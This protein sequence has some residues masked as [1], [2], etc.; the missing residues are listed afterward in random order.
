M[1]PLRRALR[2]VAPYRELLHDEQERSRRL[3]AAVTERDAT[4]GAL[5]LDLA[6]SDAR[7]RLA[8][9]QRDRA[10]DLVATLLGEERSFSAGDLAWLHDAGVEAE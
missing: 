7:L 5:R 10:R 4:I 1:T 6:V 8:N 2:W 9:N 3:R